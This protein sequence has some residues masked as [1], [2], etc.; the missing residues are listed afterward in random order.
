MKKTRSG[1]WRTVVQLFFLILFMVLAVLDKLPLWFALFGTGALL[2]ILFSRFYCGW[3]CPIQTLFR[4]VSWLLRQLK[5]KRWK[6]PGFIKPAVLRYSLLGLMTALLVWIKMSGSSFPVILVLTGAALLVVLFFEEEVWHQALCPYG[7]VLNLTSR[8]P[9][10]AL[11]VKQEACVGC[12]KCQK[13]FPAAAFVQTAD[14][15]RQIRI[16]ACL[17]CGACESVCPTQA[18]VYSRKQD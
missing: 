3:I 2:A 11:R 17:N 4:P 14:K 13:V 16:P 9:P 8:K 7:T 15:K 1:I 18:I 12:A 10:L 6:L 5:I